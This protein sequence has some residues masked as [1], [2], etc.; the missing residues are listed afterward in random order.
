MSDRPRQMNCQQ[1][2]AYPEHDT[3]VFSIRDPMLTVHGRSED[4]PIEEPHRTETCGVWAKLG[5]PVHINS[6]GDVITGDI[7]DTDIFDPE[8]RR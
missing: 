4:C 1:E 5:V 6:R 2:P 7:V 3:A 8:R